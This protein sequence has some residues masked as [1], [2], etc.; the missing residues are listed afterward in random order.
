MTG[1]RRVYLNVSRVLLDLSPPQ[2]DGTLSALAHA[3][4]DGPLP[5]G[6]A[7]GDIAARRWRR[8]LPTLSHSEDSLTEAPMASTSAHT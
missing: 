8:E 1:H 4:D 7:H 5:I 6:R 2:R 3:L